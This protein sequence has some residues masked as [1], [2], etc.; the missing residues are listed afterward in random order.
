MI[1]ISAIVIASPDAMEI[2]IE[3]AIARNDEPPQ[4]VRVIFATNNKIWRPTIRDAQQFANHHPN[5]A[6]TRPTTGPAAK[7][8][9]SQS[10]R[11]S[12]IVMS[13]APQTLAT[14]NAHPNTH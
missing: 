13:P 3:E 12:H 10:P 1:V 8:T 9:N 4:K 11:T 7:L 5:L 14:N 2:D 6:S